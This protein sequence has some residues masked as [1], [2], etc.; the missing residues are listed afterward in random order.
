MLQ[1]QL[2]LFVDYTMTNIPNFSLA[3][4]GDSVP[5]P[6]ITEQPWFITG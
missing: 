2:M 4:I 3:K 1:L 6:T 5:T